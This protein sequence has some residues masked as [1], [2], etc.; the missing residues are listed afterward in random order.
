MDNSKAIHFTKMHGIGND[1]VYID[2]ISAPLPV[3]EE[4]LPELARRM[5]RRHTG[6]GADGLIILRPSAVADV[7]M[8]MFNAD[9]SEGRMCGNGARCVGKYASDHGLV[10]KS[11]ITLDTLAGIKTLILHKG[12]DGR[13]A[14]VTVDMGVPDIE[15]SRVPVLT[16]ESQLIDS[17]V[18]TTADGELRITAVSMGNPHGVVFVDDIAAL[19]FDVTGPEL[20]CHPMWPDRAN[21]EFATVTA[22]GRIK[23]RVWERGSGE[24]MACGT[25]ACAV[26][27]AAALLDKAPRRVTV[28]L[29]GGDLTVEWGDDSHV[30]MRG[31]ATEVYSGKYLI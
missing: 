29:R 3:A 20:E 18:A 2:A 12:P 8:Q 6:I 26:A 31:P 28:S 1:Y 24:T 5:S 7:R 10:S 15:A 13:V 14:E 16:P 27:V 9:G 4:E 22:P 11:S 21:I 17:P 30:Y 23:V 25:G 19:H